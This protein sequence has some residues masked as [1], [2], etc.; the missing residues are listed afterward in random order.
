MRKLRLQGQWNKVLF[1]I[2]KRKTTKKN[3]WSQV[4]W[5]YFFFGKQQKVQ[6][7]LKWKPPKL[8]KKILKFNRTTRDHANMPTFKKQVINHTNVA[9]LQWN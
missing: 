9:T 8:K 6:Q 1:K 2:Q 4:V 5:P 7:G 3:S